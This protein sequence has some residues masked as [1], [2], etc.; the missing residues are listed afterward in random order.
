MEYCPECKTFVPYRDLDEAD[1]DGI[2]KTMRVCSNGHVIEMEDSDG[3]AIG[4]L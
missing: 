4:Q 1:E 3:N 2:V